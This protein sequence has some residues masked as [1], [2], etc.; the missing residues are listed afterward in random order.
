M[1]YITR[2]STNLNPKNPRNL[3][4]YLSDERGVGVGRPHVLDPVEVAVLV[5]V[6]V[7]VLAVTLVVGQNGVG[8]AAAAST[9]AAIIL[10]CKRKKDRGK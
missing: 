2:K 7:A 1:I 4:S 10:P 8:G 6:G 9:A 5:D 3:I